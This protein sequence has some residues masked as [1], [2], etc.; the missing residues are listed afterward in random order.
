MLSIHG[1]SRERRGIRTQ[2][3]LLDVNQSFSHRST[4]LIVSLLKVPHD[5]FPLR[6]SSLTKALYARISH[7]ATNAPSKPNTKDCAVAGPVLAAVP[8]DVVE[9]AEELAGAPVPLL[10]AVWAVLPGAGSVR[11]ARRPCMPPS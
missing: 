2:P 3:R 8:A 7:H 9:V 10:V 6:S 4:R 11:L 1:T 5:L